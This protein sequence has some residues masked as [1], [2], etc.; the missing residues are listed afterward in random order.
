MHGLSDIP[1]IYRDYLS[2]NPTFSSKQFLQSLLIMHGH[3]SILAA[4]YYLYK[5]RVAAA[6]SLISEMRHRVGVER[7]RDKYEFV[8]SAQQISAHTM[9]NVFHHWKGVLAP[10]DKLLSFQ[11]ERM[12]ELMTYY[13]QAHSSSGPEQIILADEINAVEK[14]LKIQ[15]A[16]HGER[17]HV[18]WH[19]T[20]NMS[21]AALPPTTILT[22]VEN[23]L[24]YG[25]F[26]DENFPIVIEVSSTRQ[27]LRL[28]VKNKKRTS[29][30]NITSH[31]T[32]LTGLKRRMEICY[33]DSHC[34][35]ILQDDKSF[36][37]NLSISV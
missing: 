20:G 31:L 32:G 26:N 12:Y 30:H 18:N 7:E 1:F 22:L 29:V 3:F 37:C 5:K 4:L 16:V 23:A 15:Q 25:E 11:V 6:E 2:S 33:P 9:A 8:A 17:L 35:K 10:V 13:M 14:Y 21:G 19:I 27:A 24:K 28:S 36:E 34:I